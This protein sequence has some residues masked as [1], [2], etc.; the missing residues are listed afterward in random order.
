MPLPRKTRT[1]AAVKNRYAAKVYDRIALVVKKG[2]KDAIKMRA[3][4]QGISVNEYIN[5]LIVEDFKKAK[6]SDFVH[7]Q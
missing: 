5:R 2:M 1:S 3:D 4:S 7:I 6:I